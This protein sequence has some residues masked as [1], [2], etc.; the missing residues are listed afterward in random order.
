MKFR[1]SVSSL[2]L[3][4]VMALVTLMSLELKSDR[5]WSQTVTQ[6]EIQSEQLGENTSQNRSESTLKPADSTKL[7]S[8][9]PDLD[10]L[11][12]KLTSSFFLTSDSYFIPLDVLP[13]HGLD[14]FRSSY[15]L[16]D[17][18]SPKQEVSILNSEPNPLSEFPKFP[19]TNWQDRIF[20]F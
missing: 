9:I 4:N 2:I 11:D 18:Y 5:A 12:P 19:E 1:P 17:F 3:V 15:T 20:R 6:S 8:V 16:L 7:P 10:Y 14:A 13:N